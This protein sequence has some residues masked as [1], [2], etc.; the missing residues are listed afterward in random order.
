LKMLTDNIQSDMST[1]VSEAFA[2]FPDSARNR[3]MELRTLIFQVAQSTEG[4]GPLLEDLR[5]GEPAYLTTTCKSGSTIRLGFDKASNNC[6]I[7]FICNTNLV[8][9][10]RQMFPQVLLFSKNRA[11]LVPIEGEL[12]RDAIGICLAMA[13]TYHQK[14]KN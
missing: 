3:L 12:P 2:A 8:D 6:A 4:V 10:F 9:Q 5:W 1:K 13:L 7:Y 14:S 11:I